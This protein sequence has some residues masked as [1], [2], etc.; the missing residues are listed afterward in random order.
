MKKRTLLAAAALVAC[1]GPR[2]HPPHGALVLTVDGKVEQGAFTFGADDLPQLPRRAFEGAA[3]A[4][5][6]SGAKFE[7]VAVAKLLGDEVDVARGS[8]VAVFHGE[9]GYAAV[10][11][12]ATLRQIRPVLADEVDGQPVG[13]WRAGAGPLQL[14]WPN[15]EQPGIDSDPR[16]RGWW[17]GGVTRIE[18]QSWIASYGRAL[19]VPP[20]AGDDARKGASAAVSCLSCH[21]LRGSG[22][23]A[24]PELRDLQIA[25]D[26]GKFEARMR[27]HLGRVAPPG[28]VLDPIA[29]AAAA[30]DVTAFLKAV[31]L[32]GP[33]PDDEVQVQE[34]QLPPP[35]PPI[36]T[37]GPP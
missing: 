15:L 30:H 17:V 8:D 35:P 24:G 3:P 22:G 37:P 10:V 21:K 25:A 36:M 13:K 34:P 20:G 5:R 7:G 18:M 1:A 28:T 29:T 19:R 2:P 31:E 14:A 23:T 6:P 12:L 16:M 27:E 4:P 33:R 32:A 26:P 11:P 9:G